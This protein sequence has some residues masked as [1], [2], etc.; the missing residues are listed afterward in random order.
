MNLVDAHCPQRCRPHA[1]RGGS[2]ECTVGVVFTLADR[3]PCRRTRA[4]CVRDVSRSVPQVEN[5]EGTWVL[6]I[7]SRPIDNAVYSNCQTSC[8]PQC[9]PRQC[10]RLHTETHDHIVHA[11]DTAGLVPASATGCIPGSPRRFP[12]GDAP[13]GLSADP[14]ASHPRRL[15]PSQDARVMAGCESHHRTREPT[16]GRQS[17]GRM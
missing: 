10:I 17:H 6:R 12:L 14:R 8:T 15:E 3:V 4:P 13:S 5:V 16:T 2:T 7:E 1:I 9:N 11:V